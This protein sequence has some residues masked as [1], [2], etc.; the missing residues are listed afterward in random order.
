[1]QEVECMTLREY[2]FRMKAH[3]LK[4]VDKEYDMHLNAW[5]HVQANS[6]EQKGKKTVPKYKTFK[7]FFDY[8]KRIESIEGENQESNLTERQREM[9]KIASKINS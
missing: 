6:T 8:T 2:L 7:D 3:S 4:R 5:L 1:M 9:A